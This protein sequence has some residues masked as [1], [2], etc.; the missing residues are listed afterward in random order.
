VL[1]DSNFHAAQNIG[2][3][4]RNFYDYYDRYSAQ[5]PTVSLSRSIYSRIL[6]RPNLLNFLKTKL[7]ISTVEHYRLT[8][9]TIGKAIDSTDKSFIAYYDEE[10]HNGAGKRL[11]HPR[12]IL[13]SPSED[14]LLKQLA[15][16][17]IAEFVP[18]SENPLQ[19]SISTSY[20][21]IGG[22]SY[23]VE[24]KGDGW[25]SNYSPNSTSRI[26]ST[27]EVD[28]EWTAQAEAIES[29]TSVLA[30]IP[31]FSIDF[32]CD[33]NTKKIVA[34]DL[35]LSPRIGDSAIAQVLSGEKCWNLISTYLFENIE[36]IYDYL[37]VAHSLP[38]EAL[39]EDFSIDSPAQLRY[40]PPGTFWECLQDRSLW[41]YLHGETDADRYFLRQK[42]SP[43]KGH[44][45]KLERK[46]IFNKRSYRLV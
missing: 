10:V 28:R 27:A 31:I 6:S 1:I 30:R 40:L 35:N 20:F 13:N 23:W 7:S 45:D 17:F 24:Y 25:Q 5:E 42:S 2:L 14:L 39:S 36:I 38:P 46:N 41:K 33:F 29:S 18:T 11:F 19:T 16:V 32:L 8:E 44:L 34:S 37:L 26:L 4:N 12:E 9:E 22:K 3:T 15:G 21:S 43:A